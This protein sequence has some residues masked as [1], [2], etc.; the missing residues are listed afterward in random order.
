MKKASLHLIQAEGCG[1]VT[2]EQFEVFLTSF[3]VPDFALLAK[4]L[5]SKVHQHVFQ[6]LMNAREII[7]EEFI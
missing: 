2:V 5:N 7:S 4:A 3:Q 6:N 1:V